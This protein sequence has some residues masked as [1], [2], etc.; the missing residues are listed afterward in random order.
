MG[1]LVFVVAAISNEGQGEDTRLRAAATGR[2]REPVEDTL[3][4]GESAKDDEWMG[5]R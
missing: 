2:R 1:G 4:G 3:G 5:D